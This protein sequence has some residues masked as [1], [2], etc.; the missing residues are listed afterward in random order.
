MKSNRVIGYTTGVYDL[1]H[2]GHLNLLKRAKENCDYLI[3]GV[4]TDELV[5]QYKNKTPII[6][7]EERK[8]IVSAIKYVDEVVTQTTRDKFE[9][10]KHNPF[11]IMFVGDDWKGTQKWNELEKQ[12]GEYGVKIHYF[13]YTQGTSSTYLTEVLNQFRLQV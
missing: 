2:I 4:S 12:F 6:P 3:V 7:F 1:F 13:P 5:Q 9:A 11:D 10:Y 8:T